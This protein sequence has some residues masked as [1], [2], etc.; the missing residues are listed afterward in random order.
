MRLD[1]AAYLTWLVVENGHMHVRPIPG[2]RYASVLRKAFTHAIVVGRMFDMSSTDDTWCYA[3]EADAKAALDAW[4][5]QGEPQGWVRHP[6]SGRRVSQT[7]DEF[8][9]DGP[10]GGIGVMYRRQ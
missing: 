8:G 7:A 10:V 9:D 4:D 5:G 3:S 6:M 2:K 1:E